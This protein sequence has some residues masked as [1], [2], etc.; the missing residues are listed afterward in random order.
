LEKKILANNERASIYHPETTLSLSGSIKTSSHLPI[1]N[2]TVRLT[3]I[4]DHFVADTITNINGDE[5]NKKHTGN[6]IEAIPEPVKEAMQQS[7]VGQE[8]N[9]RLDS[10]QRARQLKEV[11]INANRNNYFNPTYSDNMKN[12]ANLNRPGNA[13][14][15]LLGNRLDGCI[16]LSDCLRGK[17]F[18]VTFSQNGTPYSTRVMTR[19]IRGA[20]PMA[21]IIDGT[22]HAAIDL[23]NVI[24]DDVYSIE[25]LTSGA[26]LAIY[27]SNAPNG[28]LI[29]TLKRGAGNSSLAGI[30]V[31]G[32]ITYKFNG[33][34]KAREFYFPKYAATSQNASELKTVYWNPNIITDVNGKAS[35]D[36][37]NTAGKGNYRIVIEGIDADGNLG[38]TVYRYRVE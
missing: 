21:V 20:Q 10:I 38:R 4:K 2:G 13:D 27:G 32:L 22:Q 11:R 3:S 28:A 18:G 23:D 33:Y 24:A 5:K 31:D 30:T 19:H 1:P 36:Y 7:Y 14:Q 16:K 15:V 8:N 34:Y 6:L 26:N 35:F 25:V 29:I 12:S 17:L 9:I 37:F